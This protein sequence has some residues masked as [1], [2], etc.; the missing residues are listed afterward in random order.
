MTDEKQGVRLQKVLAQAGVASRRAAEEMID[1]GRV[2]VNGEIVIVQGRRVDPEH[3]EIRV[4]GS[5]IPT[6]R[7][8]LYYVLNKP[9]GVVS[10]MDDPDGRACLADLEGV[11]NHERLFHVGRLDTETEGLI[12]LTNDGEFAHRMTHPS[13]K[14]LK[15]Y[16]AEV[17]GFVDDKVI[18]R[19]TKGL[20]LEDGPVHPDSVRL[21]QASEM[22]SL[23]EISLHEGR[24][25]IVR[26]MMDSVAHPVRRLSRTAIGP[27]R[28]GRLGVGD[29]RPLSREELG[30]LFDLVDL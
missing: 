9:R 14:V 4:D 15:S 24:N 16:L 6:A 5:R 10:T 3:D 17:E 30:K 1:E 18:R 22:K 12:L 29:M 23:V 27:V 7:R 21:V 13:Y 2:E 8:H 20:T 28:V 19:L 26:R 11:P 25:R